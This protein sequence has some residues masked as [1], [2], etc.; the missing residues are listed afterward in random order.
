MK[1][2]NKFDFDNDFHLLLIVLFFAFLIYIFPNTWCPEC[3][4]VES[5][6]SA[7]LSA[8]EEEAM[9]YDMAT[10]LEKRD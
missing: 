8:D 3:L 10:D 2:R 1:L 4:R 9:L 6:L 7:P 5:E